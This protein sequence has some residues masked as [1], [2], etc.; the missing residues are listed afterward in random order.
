M[1]VPQYHPAQ[2]N[3]QQQMQGLSN[4]L[5]MYKGSAGIGKD[6]GIPGSQAASQSAV[7]QYGTVVYDPAT[8]LNT[9]PGLSG[10]VGGPNIDSEIANWSGYGASP[11]ASASGSASAF[12]TTYGSGVGAAGDYG[13]ADLSGA[14]GGLGGASLPTTGADAGLGSSGGGL[15]GGG[16]GALGSLG[17][18]A[19]FAALIGMGKNTEANHPNTPEGDASLGLLGPSAAQIIKDPIGMGLPTLLGVPF[20]TPFT[21]S[22]DA[23]KTKPEWSGLFGMGF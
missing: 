12:P 2:D 9:T 11:M 18:A 13:F 4:A 19:A 1:Q 5:A 6:A 8:G 15:F 16:G 14:G 3:S 20:I 21:G 17:P 23:K 10:S 22:Q 7:N